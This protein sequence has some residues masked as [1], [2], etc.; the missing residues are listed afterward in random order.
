VI[1]W[2]STPPFKNVSKFADPVVS[3]IQKYSKLITKGSEQQ[4]FRKEIEREIGRKLESHQ[5]WRAANSVKRVRTHIEN[6]L[7]NKLYL[8]FHMV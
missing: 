5:L 3:R 4:E 6:I 1:A 8:I 2:V 7:D